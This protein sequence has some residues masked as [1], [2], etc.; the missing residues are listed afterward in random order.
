MRKLILVLLAV[1]LFHSC[2]KEGGDEQQLHITKPKVSDKLISFPDEGSA[3]YFTTQAAE[4]EDFRVDF[5]LPARVV[6]TVVPS[7]ENPGEKL[8][9]FDNSELTANYSLLRQHLANVHQIEEVLIKQRRIELDRVMDLQK[10]GAATGRDVLEA[11][12]ALALQQTNLINEKALL[13]EHETILKLA[14]FSTSA[15][16]EART[17]TV[18]VISEVADNLVGKF[19]RGEHCQLAFSSFPNEA[20]SGR[21]DDIGSP[22]I[23]D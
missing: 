11:Q 22:R 4:T 6:V 18:W 12:T 21:I 13:I 8:V 17:N 19:A 14:G 2:K 1:T 23:M 9:L 7:G 5:A 15:L 16:R 3:A 10:H 20:F